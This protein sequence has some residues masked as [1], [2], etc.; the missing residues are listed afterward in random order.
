MEK[1]KI[2]ILFLP[3]KNSKNVRRELWI[4]SCSRADDFKC[5]K[6]SYKCS[7][8]FVEENGPTDK[9]PNHVPATASREKVCYLCV[10]YV[11]IL[12]FIQ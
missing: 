1:L 3:R 10:L 2:F 8:H 12:L 7:L 4:R 9:D 11:Y 5:T 6:D